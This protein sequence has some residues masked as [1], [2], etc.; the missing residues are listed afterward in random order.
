MPPAA[1][2][3]PD[4]ARVPLSYYPQCVP[5]VRPRNRSLR[6]SRVGC[7][8][9][10]RGRA[11]NFRCGRENIGHPAIRSSQHRTYP[12][13]GRASIG[14]P[15]TRSSQHRRSFDA[16]VPASDI[17]RCGRASI[18]HP[19]GVE[20]ASPQIIAKRSFRVSVH[21]GLQ[22]RADC[23]LPPRGHARS[24]QRCDF[25][26]LLRRDGERSTALL[27]ALCDDAREC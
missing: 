15:S 2:S 20:P 22:S 17:L 6:L 11:I 26:R 7:R 21:R 24:G 27:P 19:S 3:R 4:P 18:G 14:H 5:M 23:T 8:S 12:R 1:R 10:M 25:A 9:I 16:V 13:R